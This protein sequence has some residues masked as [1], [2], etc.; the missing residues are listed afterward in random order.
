MP[1]GSTRSRSGGRRR[2]VRPKPAVGR[3]TEGSGTASAEDWIASALAILV[4]LGV[5]GLVCT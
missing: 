5:I 1:A 3:G 4:A 2:D